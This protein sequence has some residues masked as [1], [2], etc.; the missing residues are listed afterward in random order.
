[1]AEEVR[2]AVEV[3][4]LYLASYYVLRGC[5][6]ASV[7]CIPTGKDVS[8]SVVMS[9]GF[10]L[11]HEVQAEYFEKR[12]SVN[13]WDFRNA[14]NQINSCIRQAKKSYER[15]ARGAAAGGAL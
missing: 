1:M 11:V 8:C 5:T 15:A 4:D 14:Y 3:M 13:L 7:R 12:A 10:D 9:G 2:D 6:I